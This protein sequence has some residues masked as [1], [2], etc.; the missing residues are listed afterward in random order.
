MQQMRDRVMTLNGIAMGQVNGEV[1]RG[2]HG[3]RIAAFAEAGVTHLQVTPVPLGDQRPAD[4]I[5]AVK[6]LAG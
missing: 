2:A 6:R 3:R 1:D 4:L 5:E